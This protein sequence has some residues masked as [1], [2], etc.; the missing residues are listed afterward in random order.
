MMGR[1]VRRTC[2]KAG[3]QTTFKLVTGGWLSRGCPV[4]VLYGHN[5]WTALVIV[6]CSYVDCLG[7]PLL[8][9][10]DRVIGQSQIR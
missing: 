6:R 9:H 5:A 8:R 10:C 4:C 3:I 1:A 7:P 2:W